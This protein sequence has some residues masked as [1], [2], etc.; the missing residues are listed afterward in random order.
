ME[1]IGILQRLK[2]LQTEDRSFFPKG[3]FP[4]YRYHSILPYRRADDNVYFT[5]FI[6][7]T[8]HRFQQDFSQEEKEIVD[9]IVSAGTL[10]IK[11]YKSRLGDPTYNFYRKDGFFPNGNFLS[12]HKRFQPT[13]DADDTAIAYRGVNHE[14]EDAQQAFNLMRKM[15]NGQRERWCRRSLKPNRKY[16]TYNTWIGSES[17]YVDLDICVIA[18]VLAFRDKYNVPLSTQDHQGVALI[19]KSIQDRSFLQKKWA[20]AAWYPFDAV[21]FYQLSEVLRSENYAFK[22]DTYTI[23]DKELTNRLSQTKNITKKLLMEIASI[24]LNKKLKKHHETLDICAYLEETKKFSYGVI[25]LLHPYEGKFFQRLSATKI[26]QLKYQCDAQ[27]LTILLERI[28]LDRRI[29]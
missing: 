28:L 8:L 29:N 10:G 16:L 15:G 4:S 7:K 9:Q 1:V 17:L 13:D 5:S 21:I 24:N 25:P 19:E 18:N 3:I 14:R 11:N 20:V 2:T 22:E 23:F 6:L 12:K 27:V 26:F